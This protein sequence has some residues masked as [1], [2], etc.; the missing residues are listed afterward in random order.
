MLKNKFKL[1]IYSGVGIL[2]MLLVSVV[3]CTDHYDELNTPTNQLTAEN[4]NSSNLGQAFAQSQF[5]GAHGATGGGGFQIG[6]NLFAD[7]WSQYYSTTA[8][9]FDS[10]TNV[11]VG[12]WSN[13]AWNYIYGTPA[14]QIQFVE[15]FT[16]DENM[17]IENAIAK[18]WRVQIFHKA[19]DYWGPIIYSEF[20]NGEVSVAYDSQQDVYN[21]FFSEL[22][23]AV[24]VLENNLGTGNAF[25]DHD[26]VFGGDERQWLT[27]ANSMRLRLAMR[28][29]YVDATLAQQEA[30]KAVAGGVM[31]ENSD[32][33]LV[34]TTEN[35]KNPKD[36]VTGWGEF[37]MSASM[38]SLL[39]GYE[40]P[41]LEDYFEP[42]D[43]GEYRGLRNGIPS[44]GKSSALND[45]GSDVDIKWQPIAWGGT[46]PDI[47]I[48]NTAEMYFLRAEGA[49]IGWNMDG[50][51]QDL[52]EQGIRISMEDRS[53]RNDDVSITSAQ[54]DAYI[55][56]TNTPSDIS[57]NHDDWPSS[58]D[59]EAA[60]DIPVAFD[61]AGDEER[62]LEQIITQKW[63]AVYPNGFEA[64]AE[65]RRTGYPKVLTRLSSGNSRV[66]E[67]ET[68]RRLTFVD[69][70][71]SNN[72]S[73]VESAIQFLDGD[74]ENDTRVWWDAK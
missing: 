28:I 41:R 4:L 65:L 22:D 50:T 25:N 39:D 55:S 68:V 14:P 9:N 21:S 70:E 56:S 16:A 31:E 17:E 24:A 7:L 29:R 73:A 18:I 2:A 34:T 1:N 54:I 10:D 15:E 13:A 53:D 47:E 27:F 62:Q 3:A 66:P 43:D 64:Y 74:D 30:E 71:Y 36:V 38:E 72:G 46:N 61:S 52:Y 58:W 8:E 69:V 23:E 63:L 37:R 20:G 11:E 48:M 42:A 59:I 35:N 40:D 44:S 12:G 26:L 57:H 5:H 32:N 6:Q 33:A 67:D 60:T 49:L 51:T 19:T 45:L